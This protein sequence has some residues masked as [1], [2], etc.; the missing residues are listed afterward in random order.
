MKAMIVDW[1]YEPIK[2]SIMHID[3]KRIAMDKTMVVSVPVVLVGVPEGVQHAGRHPRP[4]G[5]RSGDRVPAGGH[6]RRILTWT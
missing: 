5:A 2:G 1:Q 3:L 4:G 6:P